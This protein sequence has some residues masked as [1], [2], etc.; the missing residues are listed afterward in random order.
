M[1]PLIDP[2][3]RERAFG[4]HDQPGFGTSLFPFGGDGVRHEVVEVAVAGFADV[5]ALVSVGA[6]PVPGLFEGVPQKPFAHP[7][8]H[9]ADQDLG[10]ALLGQRDRALVGGEQRHAHGFQLVFELGGL[11]R[12]AGR[13]FDLLDHDC[14]EPAV[15]VA[16]L[17]QQIGQAPVAR[18]RDVERLVRMAEPAL[19]E[20]LARGLHVVEERND[21]KLRR[22]HFAAVVQLTRQRQRRVLQ[23]P[24]RGPQEHR[25][26]YLRGFTERSQAHGFACGAIETGHSHAAASSSLSRPGTVQ[27][28]TT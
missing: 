26:R 8:F 24:C 18:N 16:C 3:H 20:I 25:H 9:P 15:R 2:H 13:A 7:L 28:S 22:Q 5:P 27:G 17:G 19:V 4:V 1:P 14:L 21:H 6:E 10:G 11:M 12:P 23:I